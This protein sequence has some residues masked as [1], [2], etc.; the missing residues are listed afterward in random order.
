MMKR[1][2]LNEVTDLARKKAGKIGRGLLWLAAVVLLLAGVLFFVFTALV[3]Q[4]QL[5]FGYQI[6][7]IQQSSCDIPLTDTLVLTRQ[8][9]SYAPGD[10]VVFYRQR[11][12]SAQP[13]CGTLQNLE[14]GLGV[15]DQSGAVALL[16][17]ES[18]TGKILLCFPTLGKLAAWVN[19]PAQSSLLFW[20]GILLGVVLLSLAA[21]LMVSAFCAKK[22]APLPARTSQAAYQ[23]ETE[24]SP[25]KLFSL[26]SEEL[27][28]P[29]EPQSSSEGKHYPSPEEL[30]VL[31][32]RKYAVQEDVPLHKE[33]P[34]EK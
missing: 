12:S 15:T 31:P 4:G 2:F 13:D 8:Q 20:V 7:L 22:P 17:S 16:T 21:L 26:D 6:T 10:S 5:P 1:H 24:L 18:V 25:V 34:A 11:E 23:P 3:H 33:T 19:G 14:E 29:S 28:P 27:S 32:W 9:D 30:E